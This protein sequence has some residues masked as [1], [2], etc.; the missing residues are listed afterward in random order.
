MRFI[1]SNMNTDYLYLLYPV[2][3]LIAAYPLRNWLEIRGYRKL[4]QKWSNQLNELP[5]KEAYRLKHQQGELIICDYCGSNRQ[6]S[7]LLATVPYRPQ[8]GLIANAMPIESSFRVYSCS[9]CGTRLYG[10]RI[11]KRL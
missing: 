1:L 3:I 4:D 10:E 9:G 6:G 5:S 2:L 11:E 8:F 7:H